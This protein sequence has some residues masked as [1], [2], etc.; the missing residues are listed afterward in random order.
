MQPVS[1]FARQFHRLGIAKNFNRLFRL[2]H[3]EPALLAIL[4]MAL[5]VL[6]RRRIQIAVNEIRNIADNF[7][8]VQFVPTC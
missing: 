3:N 5:Q 2:I 8:A 7:F 4:K 6:L 1:Y